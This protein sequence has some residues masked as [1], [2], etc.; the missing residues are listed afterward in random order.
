MERTAV[1]IHVFAGGFTYGVQQRNRVTTQ[2][3]THDF[4]LPTARKMCGVE[5]INCDR[6]E[7]WPDVSGDWA[8]GN[9]RC[10]GFSCIT[11]GY[12]P[13]AHGPWAKQTKDIHDLIH[14]SIKQG[15]Q[16]IV[17]E[18]V[19]QAYSTGRE[20]LDYLR[21]ELLGPAGYNICHVLLTTATFGNAQNRRRYFFVA[22]PKGKRFNVAFPECPEF[23]TTTR[24]VIGGLE[25]NTCGPT[26]F[27]E[28]YGPDEYL[29]LSPE[30]KLCIPLLDTGWNLNDLGKYRYDL[31][32]PKFQAIWKERSSNMPFSMHS[33]HRMAYDTFC[34]TFFGSCMVQ[35]HPRLNRPLTVGEVAK[36]MGWPDIPVGRGPGAQ[37]AKGI[38][39]AVGTWLAE[40]VGYCLDDV[41]DDDYEWDYCAKT[42]N[43]VGQSFTETPAEK[44]FNALDYRPYKWK[45]TER[46]LRSFRA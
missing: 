25:G 11:S 26:R 29:D 10:T 22:Y 5:T 20:L 17:W 40:Q 2:L 16:C 19:T 35:I 36:L 3:E 30:D 45:G 38:V 39:P 9:P 6:W 46:W 41:W 14:Y 4:A 44:T 1:G 13:Q 32:P 43:F 27:R 33:P 12:G 31:I 28:E 18:S 21:D 34:P 7:D 42:Q 24:D 15:Y 8:F 23:I 37:M